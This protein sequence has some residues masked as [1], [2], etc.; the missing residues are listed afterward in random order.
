MEI[1]RLFR[2]VNLARFAVIAI[3]TM[4][5]AAFAAVAPLEVVFFGEYD[6]PFGTV[7]EVLGIELLS[8]HD[9][10]TRAV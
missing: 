3:R 5:A 4:L 6:I 8:K 1:L 10:T 9:C 2:R 7:I